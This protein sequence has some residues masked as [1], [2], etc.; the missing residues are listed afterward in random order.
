M[1]T[2]VSVIIATRD[3]AAPLNNMLA[4]LIAQKEHID[5]SIEIVV[6]DNGSRDET[7]VVV[8]RLADHVRYLYVPDPGQAHAQ[9]VALAQCE[10]PVVLL[11]DD[12][13]LTTDRW[14]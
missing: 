1:S 12:D 13:A 10:S 8:E 14:I 7:R 4:G 6:V 5:G 9:N 3:N 11:T 2:L